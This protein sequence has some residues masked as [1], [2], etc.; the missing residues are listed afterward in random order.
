LQSWRSDE[1]LIGTEPSEPL[2]HPRSVIEQLLTFCLQADVVATNPPWVGWEYLSR[3]YRD[4]IQSAWVE[5]D[6]YQS[7][8]LE[9]S[10]LKEDLSN[11]ALLAAW[12]AYLRD[13]GRSAVVL[14]PS[15]M[16]SEVA[17]RGVRRL[18]LSDGGVELKLE[19]IRLFDQMR[20][21]K[22]AS[23]PAA[24]WLIRKGEKTVFPVPVTEFQKIRPRWNPSPTDRAAEVARQVN[25]VEKV[26]EP[27]DPENT[28]SRWMITTPQDLRS[29]RRLRGSNE[30][31]PRMGVFT[32]GANG[33]F[34]LR[35]KSNLPGL[36]ARYNNI[37]ANSK[38]KV[39]DVEVEL[40]Q[41][42]VHSIARGRDIGMWQCRPEV[43]LLL[44]HTAATRMYPIPESELASAYPKTHRYLSSMKE[45]LQA[46]NGFATWE[47][48]IHQQH[49]YTLQRIGS[50]TFAPYK[51]CWRYI[52]TEFTICVLGSDPDGKTIVPN[53]K[54]MF[55]PM[56]DPDEAYFVAGFLSSA[57]V[58]KYVGSVIEK[59]Q[60]STRVTKSIEIPNYDQNQKSHQMIR[61]SCRAGHAKLQQH[62][63]ADVSSLKARIDE[64]VEK[65]L[66]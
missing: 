41:G 47:K 49:F 61:D 11:L 13:S 16:H 54:V 65:M 45:P 21:F 35:Q 59:R 66:A 29:M 33:V 28:M 26:A 53:D 20:L 51:V 5:H 18:S 37:T 52:A 12:S 58:R 9:A 48:K 1:F 34:Y 15:T 25:A 19:H 6:L 27:T 40:E 44:P 42:L 38:R 32:G 2:S 64:I 22:S 57:Q 7:K 17:S 4:A 36:S 39:P 55:I 30:L 3:P 14:R 10:F 56:D 23:T 62:A 50:Y 60:I 24:T 8:G 31:T 63:D 46:R 43:F